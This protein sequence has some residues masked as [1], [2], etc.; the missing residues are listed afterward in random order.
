M[1]EIESVLGDEAKLESAITSLEGIVATL[2]AEWGKIFAES[3]KADGRPAPEWGQNI[4]QSLESSGELLASIQQVDLVLAL[5]QL[6]TKEGGSAQEIFQFMSEKDTILPPAAI[7]V[8]IPSLAGKF[9][10]KK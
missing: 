9:K 4:Q 3:A 2:K 1:S 8:L 10:V 6:L 5:L 7:V